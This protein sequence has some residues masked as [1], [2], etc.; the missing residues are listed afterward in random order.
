M[1]DL[2]LGPAGVKIS[3]FKDVRVCRLAEWADSDHY[4][5]TAL[6][7]LPRGGRVKFVRAAQKMP[8]WTSEM[9]AEFTCR[10]SAAYQDELSSVL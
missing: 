5:V 8:L 2:V 6:V 10:H 1:H 3:R 9:V 7:W 4:L